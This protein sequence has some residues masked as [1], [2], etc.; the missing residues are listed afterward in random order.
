[1]KLWDQYVDLLKPAGELIGQTWAPDSA[2]AQA[3]LC[4]QLAMNISQ[5]Y[6][7]HCQSDPAH[8]DWAPFLNSV[9]AL[10]PNPDAVY[11]YAP[12]SGEGTYRI[13]GNR[14]TLP[15]VG[16]ATGKYAIGM[17]DP[18]GP[19]YN[20]YDVDRLKIEAG[21]S[22]EVIFSGERPAGHSGNWL[23][24]HPDS[25]FLMLREFSNN[26]G[27]EVD[28]RV[29]IER[30]DSP[31][32]K[33]MLTPEV[34]DKQLRKLFGQYVECL[35]RQ[36][37]GSIE[38]V[39][40]KGQINKMGMHDFQDLMNS[41]EWP[42]AYF[43]CIY[44]IQ[45]DEALII[46]SELPE[47]RPYWNVQVIDGLW[48]QVEQVYRQSSLNGYQAAVD[49]DGKFRAVLSLEDPGI[50]NWLDTGGNIYGM[51]IGRW[52]RCSS[53]PTPSVK[54]VRFKDL[55]QHLP[56]TTPTISAGARN[57][58]LRQRRIGAQLRRRW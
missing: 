13:I 30:L 18:P 44:D 3:E 31:P 38:R 20:N 10:Q 28:V 52:Y 56:A 12:V 51:L 57:E 47:T 54:K 27:Y 22:F 26:W 39:R 45:P 43:E 37:L 9:F 36:S 53:N 1:M 21:G 24:L 41:D 5:G 7:L 6:F 46:E 29:A 55:R 14:G 33:P 32:L 49:A 19:G 50:Q 58:Q 17:G 48:N 40:K 8:P 34:I 15:V 25:Q 23:Y 16:F 4:R 35:T 11:H 2:K 42:Q